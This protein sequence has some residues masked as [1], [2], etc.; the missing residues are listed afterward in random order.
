ML[1]GYCHYYSYGDEEKGCYGEGE[2]KTVPREVDF[3]EAG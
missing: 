1:V 3:W 2:E